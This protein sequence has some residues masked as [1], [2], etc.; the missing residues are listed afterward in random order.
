MTAR[1]VVEGLA[2][3]ARQ[4]AGHLSVKERRGW[5]RRALVLWLMDT[6]NIVTTYLSAP[7]ALPLAGIGLALVDR[8]APVC[9]LVD[10][11]SADLLDPLLRRGP[12]E[13]APAR[14]VE[15]VA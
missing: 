4:R 3:V 10:A 2:L 5:A 1:L 11:V 12:G 13:R 9:R 15:A 14:I 7:P 8:V 6:H